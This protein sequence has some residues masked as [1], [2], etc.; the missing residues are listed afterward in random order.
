MKQFY[1]IFYILLFPNRPSSLCIFL[2]V[3][4]GNV[5][6]FLSAH[7]FCATSVSRFLLILLSVTYLQLWLP[8][9]NL[10]HN[11]SITCP[12]HWPFCVILFLHFPGI[13]LHL[14]YPICV[15][16]CPSLPTHAQQPLVSASNFSFYFTPIS[17]P[18]LGP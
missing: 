6:P 2:H 10:V 18:P 9:V 16:V 5:Q 1:S 11:K 17:S 7:L 8:S 15:P 3:W 4:G 12:S 13:D 14:H